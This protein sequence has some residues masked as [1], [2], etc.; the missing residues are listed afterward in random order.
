MA[1]LT[2]KEDALKLRRGSFEGEYNLGDVTE[3]VAKNERKL[4]KK[5]LDDISNKLSAPNRPVS[6]IIVVPLNGQVVSNSLIDELKVKLFEL[7]PMIIVDDLM[8][9]EAFIKIIYHEKV[10]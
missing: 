3:R 2:V 5:L 10:I 4:L 9:F 6:G 1:H 8:V 7:H